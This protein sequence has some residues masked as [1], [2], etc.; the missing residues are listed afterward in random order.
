MVQEIIALSI[1]AVV[2]VYAV[3]AIVKSLKNK[4][5]GGCGDSCSC[6]SGKNK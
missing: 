4:N 1:V 3:Y 2:V 6:S 5:D